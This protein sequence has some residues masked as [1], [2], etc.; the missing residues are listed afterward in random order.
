MRGE[1]SASR[2]AVLVCQGRAAAHGSR[3]PEHFAD[4]TAWE[5]LRETERTVVEQVTAG[6]A[7]QGWGARV[8]FESV[9][10]C[11]EVMVPRTLAIDEALA[12]APTRQ[13]VI[14]GA[15]LD[16]RAWRLPALA[17]VRSFEVD[18]PASQADKIQRVGTR[19]PVGTLHFVPVEFGRDDLAAALATAGHDAT[20]ATTWVW[21]GVVPYLDR[22]DVVTTMEVV[23]RLSAPGSRLVINYQSPSLIAKLGRLMMRAMTW[24]ARRPDPLSGEP[25]RSAWT[26]ADMQQLLAAHG[27][28]V[29]RDE[30]LLALAG[31]LP[32]PI[33]QRMSLHNGRVVVADAPG[34][35]TSLG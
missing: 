32:M 26:P 6:T 10:A 28:V 8:E 29:G 16:G 22:A 18:H 31:R 5:F 14:L 12:A 3:A 30:D 34:S 2:T 35:P 15:G 13:A 4:P 21:E 23:A 9:R 7:P 1:R 17:G 20:S 11:A 25:Q 27:Y 19:A 24:V 33:R